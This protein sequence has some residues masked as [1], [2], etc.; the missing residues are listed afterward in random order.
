VAA[1]ARELVLAPVGWEIATYERFRREL[2]AAGGS[3][4]QGISSSR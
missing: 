4:S 1:V 2:A 3:R